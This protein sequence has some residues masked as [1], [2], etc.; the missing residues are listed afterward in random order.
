MWENFGNPSQNCQ[1]SFQN[2]PKTIAKS[3]KI[4][5]WTVFGAKSR[6]GWLLGG[7]GR[8]GYST[9]GAFLAESDAPRLDFRTPGKSKIAQKTH[10]R[11]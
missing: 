4:R 11:G 2:Q 9:F 8:T 3:I 1:T 7:P 10:F 6:P 5:P